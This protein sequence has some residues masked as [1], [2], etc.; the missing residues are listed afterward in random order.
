MNTSEYSALAG[1]YSVKVDLY[2]GGNDELA[3]DNHSFT[4][5]AYTNYLPAFTESSAAAGLTAT[6]IQVSPPPGCGNFPDFISGG[7]GAAIADYDGDGLDDI[8]AVDAYTGNGHLWRNNGNGT[9]TDNASAAGIPQLA[10]ES[11]A[12]FADIDND[13]FPDL[14]ILMFNA[15]NVV[16]H[17]NGNGTF[18]DISS[19]AGIASPV[20]QNNI[21]A[22]W[23]DYDGDGFL[24]VYITVHADCNATNKNDHLYH[25]NGNNT[26]TDVSSYL[27]G[28]SAP[29][30]NGRGLAVLFIDYNQDGRPDIYLGNDEGTQPYSHPNVLWRNDGP[31][32][33]GGWIFT[34][35]S[36]SSG[37]GVAMSSMGIGASDYNHTGRYSL[38]ISNF[39][40]NV[41]LQQE[42]NATFTI[43]QSDGFGDAHV[44]RATFPGPRDQ[45]NGSCPTGYTCTSVIWGTGFYD[46][47]NDGWE[48]LYMAGGNTDRTGTLVYQNA[49]FVNN[50][51]GTFLEETLP[52]GLLN[53]LSLK[54]PTAIVA[55]FN[56]DGFMDIFQ[57]GITQQPQLFINNGR[58]A[59]NPY[60]WLELKLVGVASNRDAVGARIT[61]SIGGGN[62]IRTVM[63][64]GTYEGNHTL[65]QHFGLG[66]ATQVDTLTITWPSGTVQTLSGIPAN[67]KLVVTEQQ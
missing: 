13:G 34:D 49:F 27:G 48:D 2:D 19:T 21:G 53:S 30:L 28:S 65:V 40:A 31:D 39:G 7:A 63:N 59:G 8:F 52:S 20:N 32:G 16:L 55:D 24:D 15:Q 25:N 37:A 22:T 5:N 33:L 51:D 54:E 56:S 10:Y 44:A 9:F 43:V 36:A 1:T 60:N 12:S 41:L 14:L 35:V 67:Q 29:D 11:G 61:A 38:F 45:V 6:R 17:N 4:R 47:N 50:Q 58:S 42:A 62:Q 57:W 26:F 66:S 46:F 23:A 3:A 18:T 64:G